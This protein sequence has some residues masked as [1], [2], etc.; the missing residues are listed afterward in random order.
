M[1]VVG[2]ALSVVLL[3]VG[4]VFTVYGEFGIGGLIVAVVVVLG[5]LSVPGSRAA[6]TA[7]VTAIQRSDADGLW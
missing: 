4:T 5:L 7:G 2:A 6:A 1:L 3:V